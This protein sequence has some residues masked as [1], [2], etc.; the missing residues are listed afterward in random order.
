MSQ[1]AQILTEGARETERKRENWI[2]SSRILSAKLTNNGTE[3]INNLS[4]CVVAISQLAHTSVCTSL[5][6]MH[7]HPVVVNYCTIILAILQEVI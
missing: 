7:Y 6:V 4:I 2:T 3:I 5:R 1:A